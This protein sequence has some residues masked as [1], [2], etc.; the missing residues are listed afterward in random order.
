M[1]FFLEVRGLE[2]GQ[3][4]VGLSDDLPILELIGSSGIGAFHWRNLI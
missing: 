4:K 3:L 1:L 2:R